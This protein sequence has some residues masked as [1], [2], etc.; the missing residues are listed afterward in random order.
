MAMTREM[1]TLAMAAV[2]GM[3]TGL[4]TGMGLGMATAQAMATGLETG[5]A[6]GVKLGQRTA[7]SPRTTPTTAA[8]RVARMPQA[9]RG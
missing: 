6:Q 8:H 7:D 9:G 1:T 2:Q 5:T 4:E 3:A